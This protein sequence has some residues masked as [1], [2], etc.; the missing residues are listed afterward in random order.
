MFAAASLADVLPAVESSASFNF[1]GSDT[2]AAQLRAGAKADVYAAASST[3][4]EQLLAEGLLEEPRVFATNRLVLIVPRANPAG[5]EV[6]TDLVRPGIRLVLGA[7]GV[8]VGDYAREALERLEATRALENVVSEEDS[9]SGVVAKVALGDADAGFVYATDVKPVEDEV[10]VI[11]L[12]SSAQPE[13][14]YLIAV[15]AGADHPDEARAFVERVL[16]DE[17]RRALSAAGFGLP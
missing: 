2:L 4:P 14:R 15:V 8:P 12:P 6:V 5:I 10:A 11:E 3:Y 1:A 9:V 16:S 13:I 17:G 7:E